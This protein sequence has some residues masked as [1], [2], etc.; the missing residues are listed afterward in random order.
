MITFFLQRVWS[1]IFPTESP[2]DYNL[3]ASQNGNHFKVR[4]SEFRF[5]ARIGSENDT[6]NLKDFVGGIV[7]GALINLGI[8]PPVLVDM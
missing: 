7:K 3:Q 5:L 6:R 4:R 2:K 1:F 8:E